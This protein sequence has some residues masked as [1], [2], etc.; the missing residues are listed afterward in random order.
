MVQLKQVYNLQP[1][2]VVVFH[3]Q[4]TTRN[5]KLYR[6]YRQMYYQKLKAELMERVK[7]QFD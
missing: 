1:Y 5:A 3:G 6:Y 7:V 2:A 4:R